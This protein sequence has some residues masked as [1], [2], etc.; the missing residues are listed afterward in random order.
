MPVPPCL[1]PLPRQARHPCFSPKARHRRRRR[2]RQM[3]TGFP[4]ARTMSARRASL[5][6]TRNTRRQTLRRKKGAQGPGGGSGDTSIRALA[7]PRR[8]KQCLPW[9]PTHAC[10][11]GCAAYMLVPHTKVGHQ[12]GRTCKAHEQAAD[13]AATQGCSHAAA[14]AATR[15]AAAASL[16]L[17]NLIPGGRR[18]R[19]SAER[20]LLHSRRRLRDRCGCFRRQRWCHR[21]CLCWSH[22]GH[23]GRWRLCRR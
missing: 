17:Q 18:R 10:V 11:H 13:N 12:Q 6:G 20:P 3:P 7:M 19:F 9:W 2:C 22:A 14:A 23:R 4:A 16:R 5:G 21:W 1:L 8:R 15:A